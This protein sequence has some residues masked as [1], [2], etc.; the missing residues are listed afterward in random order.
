MSVSS[1]S[2]KKLPNSQKQLNNNNKSKQN[3]NNLIL[4]NS[5]ISLSSIGKSF[6]YI[7][8]DVYIIYK[9]II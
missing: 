1:S 4:P 5:I 3:Q 9:Y 7:L 6:D 8:S 2:S